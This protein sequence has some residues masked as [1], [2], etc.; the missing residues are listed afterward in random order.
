MVMESRGYLVVNDGIMP[1]ASVGSSDKLSFRVGLRC[2]QRAV[3]LTG[4]TSSIYADFSKVINRIAPVKNP[5]RKAKT[6][7]SEYAGC[8]E[9]SMLRKRIIAIARTKISISGDEFIFRIPE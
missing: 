1:D 9:A 5:V 7:V 6:L 8:D 3:S 2:S 4:A